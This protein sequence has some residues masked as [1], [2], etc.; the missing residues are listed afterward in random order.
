MFENLPDGVVAYIWLGFS[1]LVFIGVAFLIFWCY[2]TGQFDE[3]IKHQ[4]FDE[5]DDD[6]FTRHQ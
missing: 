3:K 5:E 6:R 4:I 2:K 1:G